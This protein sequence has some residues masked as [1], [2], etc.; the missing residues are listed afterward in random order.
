MFYLRPTNLVIYFSSES[1]EN[2]KIKVANVLKN[3]SCKCTQKSKLQLYSKI[4]AAN[5][6][7]D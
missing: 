1:V 6:L 7:K 5:V 3:R 2:V 4:K